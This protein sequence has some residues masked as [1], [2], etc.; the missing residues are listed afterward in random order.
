MMILR[1]LLH[2]GLWVYEKYAFVA[3]ALEGHMGTEASGGCCGHGRLK[4][5]G[6][7][8]KGWDTLELA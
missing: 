7:Q 6:E 1:D 4:A 2:L 3:A 5:V 8:R